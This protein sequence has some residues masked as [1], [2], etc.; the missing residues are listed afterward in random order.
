MSGL[1]VLGGMAIEFSSTVEQV[2]FYDP[3]ADFAADT[4][5]VEYRTD[6]LT[7]QQSRVV[8]EWFPNPPED[9]DVEAYV[10]DGED[11]VFCPD[12]VREATPTYPDF[13]G[14]DRGSV[15]EAVSFP[16]LFPYGTGSNVVV[17]TED[18][19]RPVGD[20][21]AEL[22][23][24]GL[25]CALEYVGA[26]VDHEGAQFASVNMNLLPSSGSSVVHPHMQAIVDDHGTNET[27][28][29]LEAE[30]A[31]YD[32]RGRSYWAE[33]REEEQDGPRWVGSTG[34]VAWLAPFAP[35]HQYHVTGVTDATGI[36][37]PDP[38][39]RVVADLARGIETVL[40]YYEDRGLNAFNFALGL[41]AAEPASP[42]VVD[43]VARPTFDRHYVNDAF[44]LQALHDGRVLD[45]PPEEYAPEVGAFFDGPPA[46]TGCR[47]HPNE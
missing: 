31:H 19:F 38:D 2:P 28:R 6:P 15:G 27:R 9:P 10:G 14:F 21:P 46:T 41:V 40:S 1:A 35:I 32:D 7:G 37:D 34:D 43:I 16:N 47:S 3:M 29:R 33:L 30:R 5:P 17:L 8:S 39:G 25:A 22:L 4:R 13:V 20:L 12:R 23:A 44:Y 11:C 18:H 24:D 26:V 36:P 42:A 45:V